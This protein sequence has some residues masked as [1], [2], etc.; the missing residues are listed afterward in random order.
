MTKRPDVAKRN[1]ENTRDL[2]GRTFG[3]LAVQHQNGSDEHGA[4]WHCKC[5]CGNEVDVSASELLRP[6][7]DDKKPTRSCGCIQK[8]RAA[9]HMRQVGKNSHG[10][11][12]NLT[13]ETI[14]K[15]QVLAFVRFEEGIGAIYLVE[16]DGKQFEKAS[17]YLRRIQKGEA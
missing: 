15:F 11:F 17:K 14:G 6:K 4:I 13:G 2:T 10:R 16:A 12:K 7:T 5:K 3:R 9:K 1:V 8:E